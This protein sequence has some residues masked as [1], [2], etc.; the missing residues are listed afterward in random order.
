MRLFSNFQFNFKLWHQFNLP[1]SIN[2]CTP[3]V[4]EWIKTAELLHRAAK[5]MTESCSLGEKLQI[6][7]IE[8]SFLSSRSEELS[9]IAP[10][11]PPLLLLFHFLSHSHF[12]AI[13]KTHCTV[14]S[15][16]TSP[17]L[18]P[19]TAF[20]LFF[21]LGHYVQFSQLFLSSLS[22]SSHLSSPFTNIALW[23]RL[24][25]N[26]KALFHKTSHVTVWQSLFPIS[27][28]LN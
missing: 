17:P 12:S 11:S 21:P 5:T 7:G 25:T 6:A 4:S 2:F 22:G 18:P 1:V 10:L 24:L 3:L 15:E 8:N 27:R 28:R 20:V 19:L 16:R 9:L 14:H 13:H 26:V 23:E